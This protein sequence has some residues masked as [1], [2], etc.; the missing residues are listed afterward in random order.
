MA[1]FTTEDMTGISGD[2]IETA[3]IRLYKTL[4]V[5]FSSLNSQNVKS[6]QTDKTKISSS[7]G[8]TEIDG[9]Q[10]IMRDAAGNRRLKIGADGSGNFVFTL[11]NIW[12]DKSIELSSTGD[13]V[14]CGDIKTEKDASVGNNLYIGEDNNEPGV[15]KIQFYN[16]VNDDSRK[17]IIRARKESN[18]MV[19]LELTAERIILNTLS[20]VYGSDGSYFITSGPYSAYV[21]I[22]GTDYPVHFR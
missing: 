10:I 5:M 18:G 2:N 20:G 4:D 14:F 13:A 9:A 11:N 8:Y 3:L 12:G 7:N 22:N 19:A 16:D 6:I 1:D 15:K 21:T 17:A